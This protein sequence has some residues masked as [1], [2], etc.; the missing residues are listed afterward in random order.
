M[1]PQKSKKRTKKLRRNGF[2]AAEEAKLK[3]YNG[4]SRICGLVVILLVGFSVAYFARIYFAAMS[5]AQQTYQ[6]SQ[7]TSAAIS[8]RKPISILV[9]GVD[10][11]IEG[12]HDRGNSD[13]MILLTLNPQKKSAT[14]TSIPR[15]LLVDVKGDGA[16][17]GKYFM[18]RVNSAYQ[19]GGSSASAK[20]VSSLLN[21][22]VD[23][24]MEVQMDALYK[25]VDAL[26]GVD[27]KVPFSFSYDWAD[28]HKGMQHLNGR[29]ALAYSRMRKEDPKGDYGRQMRQRQIIQ[30]IVKKGMN[31]NSIDNYRKI[32]KIFSKYVRT[33][34]TF[35]DMMSIALHYRDCAAN[36][37][38]G[39][40]HGHDAWIGDASMQVAATSEL[41]RV[42]NLVRTN[43]GLKKETL[44]NEET[45]QN[46]LQKN[47]KW[48][49][50]DAFRNYI[51]YDK[52]S[53][54]E[55]YTNSA[56][57]SDNSSD[58]N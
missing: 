2:F 45:R 4:F 52:D 18:F 7:N 25:L 11:G 24:T 49:K 28:F 31:V 27:V 15:D 57:G 21:V 6:G 43:L 55:P 54:T 53:D 14:M 23:Y 13:T 12:R 10:Q 8:Q 22:K 33:N 9:L 20:T 42:S 5:S 36:V 50:P 29:H 41:Q 44:H 35:N 40:I 19:V 3:N 38:S 58:N 32:L 26:G 16:N 1:D 51:V 17:G 30:A 48:K 56:F 39:Y 37:K 46:S 47:I 34:L